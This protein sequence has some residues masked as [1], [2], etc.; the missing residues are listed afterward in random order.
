MGG[1]VSEG[2]GNICFCFLSVLSYASY[3]NLPSLTIEYLSHA[4][5]IVLGEISKLFFMDTKHFQK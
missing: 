4:I 2:F 5:G 3:F 1:L